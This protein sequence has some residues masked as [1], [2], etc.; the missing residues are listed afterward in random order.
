[1]EGIDPSQPGAGEGEREGQT[2]HAAFP[3][4]I[5][6]FLFNNFNVLNALIDEDPELAQRYLEKLGVIYRYVLNTRQEEV[7]RLEDELSFIRDYLFLLGIRYEEQLEC[8]IEESGTGGYSDY[9]RPPFRSW[10][11]TPSA[12]TSSPC[13]NP[14]T[15][16]LYCGE[17]E[18]FGGGEHAATQEWENRW[19]GIRTE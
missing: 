11:R 9:R 6:Y 5:P 10:W 2:G 12:I 8:S 7:I 13:R 18:Y 1:M 15:S 14:C 17:G 16:R 3:G 4:K 19:R